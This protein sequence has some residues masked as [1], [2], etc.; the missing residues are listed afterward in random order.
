MVQARQAPSRPADAGRAAPAGAAMRAPSEPMQAN[1]A[2][3]PR[4]ASRARSLAGVL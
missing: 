1:N 3:G 4:S 2:H